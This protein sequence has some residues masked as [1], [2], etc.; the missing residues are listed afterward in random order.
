MNIKLDYSMI[1]RVENMNDGSFRIYISGHR[2]NRLGNVE[3]Y[4]ITLDH[5]YEHWL[6]AFLR[7]SK[8]SITQYKT[9]VLAFAEKFG[10]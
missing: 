7:L 2:T 4:N 5:V 1:D 9:K 3:W 8:E 6:V 10:V